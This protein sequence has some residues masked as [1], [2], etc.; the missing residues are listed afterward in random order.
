M[1]PHEEKRTVKW[2]LLISYVL[3]IGWDAFYYYIRPMYIKTSEAIGLPDNN[4]IWYLNYIV[5]FVILGIAY[6]LSKVNKQDWIKYIFI[7]SYLTVSFLV[8]IVSFHGN[9]DGYTSGNVVEIFL[10]L[11]LPIFLNTR[12]FWVVTL[13]FTL[14]YIATGILLKTSLVLVPIVLLVILSGLSFFLLVR[15]QGYVRAVS[16]SY[17][18]QLEGIVKG[19]IATLEL[20]DPYTRGHSE[21]VAKYALMFANEI[22]KFSKEEQK[23]FYYACLL[24]DIG[25]VNIPD[26]I[27][28]KPG[29]LTDEEFEIIKTH[30][31]V[32]AEAVKNVEGIKN[33]IYVIRSH[34]E[35]W[36]GKGYPDQLKGEEIPLL[37]R[38]SAIADAFDAMT[39]SRSYRDAMPFEEAY[40]R[41]IKGQGSQFDP[42][43]VDKFKKIYPAWIKFHQN[44]PWSEKWE[45]LREVE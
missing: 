42:I 3:I 8:D 22:G 26:Q 33:S 32:G 43:L 37:A 13:G 39:S 14:K 45:L 18:N 34:H 4:K 24:H 1:I 21:R 23:S 19:V 38:V 2:Y 10:I 15:F 40:N 25:K 17:D 5:L 44:Y 41:I 30:P 20:K 9:N 11:S 12:Y 35:R 6:Y 28:M 27:L 7:I 31:V 36:D 16:T 29:K